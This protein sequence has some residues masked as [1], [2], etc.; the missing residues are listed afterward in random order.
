[1]TEL[2]G[3]R[4]WTTL[5]SSVLAACV[6]LITIVLPSEYDIDPLGVFDWLGVAS[7]DEV[8]VKI[9][10]ESDRA[11]RSDRMA[12]VLDPFTSV[13]YKYALRRGDTVLFRWRAEG[14]VVFDLHSERE[15]A[16][17]GVATSFAVGRDSHRQG[18]YTAAFPGLHGWFWENRGAVPVTVELSTAG[19]Y[20]S[21]IVFDA[22]GAHPRRIPEQ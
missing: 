16:P 4:L 9:H 19:Q 15:G 7:K 20:E 8:N 17:D 18:T 11:F 12:F 3:N 5:S 13:E 2:A 21:A 10:A 22:Q 6:I 1:M 14:E